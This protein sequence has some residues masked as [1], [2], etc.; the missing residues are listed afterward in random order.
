M[1]IS[2]SPCFHDINERGL[3]ARC[4]AHMHEKPFSHE[5]RIGIFSCDPPLFHKYDRCW[6]RWPNARCNDHDDVSEAKIPAID[7]HLWFFPFQFSWNFGVIL[8]SFMVMVFPWRQKQHLRTILTQLNPPIKVY[9]ADYVLT[10]LTLLKGGWSDYIIFPVDQAAFFVTGILRRTWFFSFLRNYRECAVVIVN[11][12]AALFSLFVFVCQLKCIQPRWC[13][14]K[15]EQ[16][17]QFNENQRVKGGRRRWSLLL[18]S[19]SSWSECSSLPEAILAFATF[20]TPIFKRLFLESNPSHVRKFNKK[21]TI[22]SVWGGLSLRLDRHLN[23]PNSS[24][25]SPPPVLIRLHISSPV[26]IRFSTS[27][28]EM[29][30]LKRGRRRN[31]SRYCH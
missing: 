19:W 11:G 17:I 6:L 21:T 31:A 15:G 20:K 13:T 25:F 28:I 29:E 4:D 22:I 2:R 12:E 7:L 14:P 8:R 27:H 18:A 3:V 1:Y 9:I 10:S 16:Q 23:R 24:R 5:H 26:V 30:Y